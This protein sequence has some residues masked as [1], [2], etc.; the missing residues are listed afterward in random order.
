MVLFIVLDLTRLFHQ[1]DFALQL[2]RKRREIVVFGG[3]GR[4]YLGVLLQV[5]AIL[6]QDI[7][8]R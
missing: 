2:K 8:Q 5:V 3:D 7:V 4:A 1:V 6:T